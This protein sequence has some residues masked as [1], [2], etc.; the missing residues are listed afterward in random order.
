MGMDQT[1]PPKQ[2]DLMHLIAD[3]CI[4]RTIYVL[5]GGD[6]RFNRMLRALGGSTS[7]VTLTNRLKKLESAGI[8][9]RREEVVDKQ[10][11]TY[12]LTTLGRDIVPIVIEFH[13]LTEK[14]RES[15]IEV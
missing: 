8:V 9:K 4:L 15:F 11:V 5:S 10:S 13:K 7:T 2:N 6:M 3:Y 14:L 12:S 1:L